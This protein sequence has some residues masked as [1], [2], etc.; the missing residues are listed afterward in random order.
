MQIEIEVKGVK[1]A[2]DKFDP[3]KVRKAAQFCLNRAIKSGKTAASSLIREK[4]NIKKSDLD[5]KI[6]IK[7]A[8]MSN[9][10]AYLTV[11]GEPISLMHFGAVQFGK[12]FY[13]SY[14]RR[15]VN[16]RIKSD[17]KMLKRDSKQ[18]GVKVQIIKGKN[19]LLKNSWIGQGKGGTVLVFQRKGKARKP[20]IA[21]K[22]YT[23]A[24]MFGK[25]F[26]MNAVKS[27][28]IEQWQ[29]EWDNQVKRFNK[30]EG[31]QSE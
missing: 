19:I 6:T 12:S 31:W 14:G 28:I 23:E 16:R 27:R 13:S 11:R 30:G 4:W 15:L 20:F 17:G 25:D 7:G 18:L 3:K 24:S 1:E 9:L 5:R 2:L 10:S 21:K 29:K 22:V 8:V 26:I